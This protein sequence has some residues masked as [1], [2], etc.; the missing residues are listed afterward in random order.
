MRSCIINQQNN[1]DV[2]RNHDEY[3]DFFKAKLVHDDILYENFA[4]FI[5][6]I[7]KKEMFQIVFIVMHNNN[8]NFRRN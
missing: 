7:Q 1:R 4:C 2:K 6:I 3:D 8:D 5:L